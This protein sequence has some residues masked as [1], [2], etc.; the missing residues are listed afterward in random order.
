MT[1]RGRD[2][3][4]RRTLTYTYA[5]QRDSDAVS[6]KRVM[7]CSRA[8]AQSLPVRSPGSRGCRLFSAEEALVDTPSVH[9]RTAVTFFVSVI[10]PSVMLM[11]FIV[12]DTLGECVDCLVCSGLLWLMTRCDVLAA[13]ARRDVSSAP[14]QARLRGR[15]SIRWKP[16]F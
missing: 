5:L 15:R 7:N 13:G 14:P 11:L 3:I 4:L 8:S 2:S 1:G 10:F 9:E 16:N 6:R 12:K